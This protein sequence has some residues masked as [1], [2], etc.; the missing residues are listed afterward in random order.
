MKLKNIFLGL[1]CLVLA[2]CSDMDYHEYSNYGEDY[3]K[4]TYAN[5]EGIVTSIYG[6]LDYDFGQNYSG[7]MLASACDEAEYSSSTNP[8]C[9]F[10]N[11]AWSASDAKD[12]TWSNSYEAIQLCNYYLEH[13]QGLTF[14][15][16]ALNNDYPDQMIRYR[17]FTHEVRFLR[18]YFY[19]NLVRQYGDVPYFTRTVT[20]NDVNSLTRAP[21]NDVFDSIQAECDAVIDSLPANYTLFKISPP[22]TARP[23]KYA[24]MALKARAAL[25]QASPLFNT[26]NDVALWRKAA[27]ANKMVLDSCLVARFK[28]GKYADLW[29]TTNWSNSEMIFMRRYYTSSG[30]DSHVLEAYNFPIGV[31]GGGGG[32]CPSQN[33]VDAYEMQAT[34]KLWNEA[35]S[36]YDPAN[37]YKGRDP[38]FAMTIVKNG[39]MNWPKSNS[40]AIETYYGGLNGE[41]L[42]NATP[43]GYYLKKYLDA[44]INLSANSTYKDS[45]HTWITFRLGEFYLNYAEAVFKYLGSADATS[46]EFPMSAREAVNKIRERADV[47]MPDIPVGLSN[48]DFWAK[49]ENERMVELAFEGHRFFDLR[50]WKEGDKLASITEMKITKNADGTFTY[51]RN[52]VNRTWKDKMYLFPISQ[53]ERQ[54]NTNLVQNTGW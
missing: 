54:K 44:S 46:A 50:R 13:F 49:Y 17:N 10:T 4:Q 1:T 35:G 12:G 2:S 47:N 45:R 25:Y 33:L 38:R 31:D 30:R 37:P 20:T 8:V 26:D 19:F 28:L 34:G 22:E 29:G 27:Q 3:I 41:P 52:I 23:T 53:S 11:G 7:G 18:A 43:T 42:T 15:E 51:T 6:Y 32:N 48:A 24:A 14:D 9:G 40:N 36:G 5:V 16:L 21:Y 39:D